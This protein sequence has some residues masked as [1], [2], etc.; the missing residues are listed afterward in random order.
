M[1][2]EPLAWLLTYGIHST[3][4]LGAAW[5]LSLVLP[6]R[7]RVVRET[8]WKAALLGAF[9]T[10]SFQVMRTEPI[11]DLRHDPA[12][13]ASSSGLSIRLGPPA[14]NL[15]SDRLQTA[16]EL[17]REE[18]RAP[19]ATTLSGSEPSSLRK[20]ADKSAL[21]FLGNAWTA[22]RELAGGTA[23]QSVVG[24]IAVRPELLTAFGAVSILLALFGVSR[25]LRAHLALRRRTRDRRELTDGAVHLTLARLRRRAGIR[26]EIRLTESAAIAGPIAIGLSE[27]CVPSRALEL[28]EE[29]LEALLAHELGHLAR[30]DPLWANLSFAIENLFFFQP[31]NRV[32]RKRIQREA[33]YLADDWAIEQTGSGFNLARCLATVAGW[34]AGTPELRAASAMAGSDSPLVGRVE[35]LLDA[36]PKKKPSRFV[37]W[38]RVPLCASLLLAVALLAPEVTAKVAGPR[39]AGP[40]PA[41]ALAQLEE[42]ER[43]DRYTIRVEHG[44]HGV[45]EVRVEEGDV[46]GVRLDGES[47]PEDRYSLEGGVLVVEDESGEEIAEIDLD[48]RSR[49][50]RF[51]GWAGPFQVGAHPERI[52][53]ERLREQ[54]AAQIDTESIQRFQGHAL[55]PEELRRSIEAS[56]RAHQARPWLDEEV[57]AELRRALEAA[58]LDMY[59]LRNRMDDLHE[60]EVD[61]PSEAELRQEI[62]EAFQ[63]ARETIEEDLDAV[64]EELEELREL[65]DLDARESERLDEEIEDLERDREEMLDQL[66]REKARA[67]RQLER[68]ISRLR[69][70]TGRDEGDGEEST[71]GAGAG[72]WIVGRAGSG[73]AV[74]RYHREIERGRREIERTL[75]DIDRMR[76]QERSEGRSGDGSDR[77]NVLVSPHD[78]GGYAY[79][80]STG[81]PIVYAAAPISPK[82]RVASL[83]PVAASDPVAGPDPVAVLATPVTPHRPAFVFVGA[84]G[85]APSTP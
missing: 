16:A 65:Q 58:R 69:D 81:A 26:Q 49:F 50:S 14:N 31:L 55:D 8:T 27:I 57:Y 32:A 4:F 20:P 23:L 51:R 28:P 82:A 19:V 52:I 42:L 80:F 33:E 15:R 61:M 53:A 34:V 36:D 24:P 41:R 84:S 29:E 63:Q 25:I 13:A 70:H 56:V 47:V 71:H 67:M 45:V 73:V 64:R 74:Q 40:L 66:D 9:L 38:M 12:P 39:G 7:A 85:S 30:R 44:S 37:R 83:H 72:A 10:A 1:A 59:D 43:L 21:T 6:D 75:R 3:L 60:W 5:L 22:G 76:R 18:E 79:A 54:I 77:M 17:T 48:L 35:R 62:E 46:V 78:G 68:R 2:N 11:A